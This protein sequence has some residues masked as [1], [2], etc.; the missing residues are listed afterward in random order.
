MTPSGNL[1]D[2]ADDPRWLFMAVDDEH[3]ANAADLVSCGVENGAPGQ[4]GDENSRG[5]HRSN[6]DLAPESRG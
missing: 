4:S 1:D 5:A 2:E 3:V 6:L